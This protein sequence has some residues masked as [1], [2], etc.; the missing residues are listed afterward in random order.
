MRAVNLLA[1]ND[2]STETR[3]AGRRPSVPIVGGAAAAAVC[4]LLALLFITASSGV[5][6]KQQ[7]L[8]ALRAE[9][10]ALAKA[11]G[12]GGSAS[13]VAERR[14]REAALAGA[15]SGRIAWDRVLRRLAL[16][17]PRDVWIT[18][19]TASAPTATTTATSAAPAGGAGTPTGFN[20][21]GYALSHPQVARTLTR[22]A[23]LPDLSDVQ[24]V[25]NAETVV[26]ER[27]L[28]T[29]TIAAN[30]RPSGASR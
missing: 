1:R 13:L 21:R 9:R 20:L 25:S 17:V 8:E 6:S 29:F 12:S 27:R 4:A 23:V 24:L 7:D 30:I 5:S 2:F 16:V 3:G 15:L 19:I 22:L 26:E 10:A 28:F 18:G 14:S 11:T